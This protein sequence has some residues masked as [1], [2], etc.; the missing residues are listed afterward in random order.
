MNNK[1]SAELKGLGDMVNCAYL[2]RTKG[3]LN[4]LHSEILTDANLKC[5]VSLHMLNL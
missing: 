1:E 2:Q 5:W 3:C 4:I